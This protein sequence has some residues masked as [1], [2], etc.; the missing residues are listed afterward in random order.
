MIVQDVQRSFELYF[1]RWMLLLLVTYLV[2]QQ[3]YL[4][5]E[6]GLNSFVIHLCQMKAIDVK[7][8]DQ[9]KNRIPT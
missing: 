4:P 9:K 8:A 5:P 3:I 2:E 1:D 7:H 6:F